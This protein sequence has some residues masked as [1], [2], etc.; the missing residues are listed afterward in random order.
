MKLKFQKQ[1]T[2]LSQVFKITYDKSHNGGSFSFSEGCIVIGISCYKTDPLFTFQVINHELMEVVLC[3]MAARFD[4]ARTGQN[5]LF[6]FD[7]QT[8]EN[9]IQVFTEAQQNFICK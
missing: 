3:S 2:I 5:Y 6:N 7:H 8:F 9:A 1:V 4:N